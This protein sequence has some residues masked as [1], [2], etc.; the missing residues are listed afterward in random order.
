MPTSDSILHPSANF[1]DCTQPIFVWGLPRCITFYFWVFTAFQRTSRPLFTPKIC[2]RHR[3][4][5]KKNCFNC[6][7]HYNNSCLRD[8]GD[9]IFPSPIDNRHFIMT[10]QIPD[11]IQKIYFRAVYANV[12]WVLKLDRQSYCPT[13]RDSAG[14]QRRRLRSLYK[15]VRKMHQP[16]SLQNWANCIDYSLSYSR[17]TEL[18]NHAIRRSFHK[19]WNESQLSLYNKLR[20]SGI[21][22]S[23]EMNKQLSAKRSNHYLLWKN[24]SMTYST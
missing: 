18:E 17:S 15:R 24:S 7:Y 8:L 6:Q 1:H 20:S 9:G 22:T 10:L 14:E 11:I 23:S 4:S 5:G 12:H 3:M 2:S 13:V 19:Y 16:E 21:T